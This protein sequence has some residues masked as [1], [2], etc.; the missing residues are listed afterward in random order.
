VHGSLVRKQLRW[1]QVAAIKV[2]AIDG[3]QIHLV[4]V[5]RTPDVT[6]RSAP[7]RANPHDYYIPCCAQLAP[8]HLDPPEVAPN[9]KRE[10]GPAVLGD[11]FEHR[12]AEPRCGEDDRLFRNC[13]LDVGV[14]DERMFA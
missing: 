10:I 9:L 12:D 14:H 8:P 6:A 4:F 7:T 13:S 11:W 2:A 1:Q 3:E 5:V